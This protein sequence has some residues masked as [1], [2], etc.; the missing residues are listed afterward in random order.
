MRQHDSRDLDTACASMDVRSRAEPAVI[1]KSQN[2]S[3]QK[4]QMAFLPLYH[5]CIHIKLCKETQYR[6]IVAGDVP[7][8]ERHFHI[9]VCMYTYIIKCSGTQ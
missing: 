7:I 8:E 2:E 4:H 5:V 9:T 1:P 3:G 6:V